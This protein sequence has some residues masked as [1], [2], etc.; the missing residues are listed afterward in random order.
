[1]ICEKESFQK[2][3]DGI[4]KLIH[5]NGKKKGRHKHRLYKC[6]LCGNFHIT[7][8]TKNLRTPKDKYP[9]KME[10]QGSSKIKNV[11]AMKPL[12][13]GKKKEDQ[14][15]TTG[16]MMTKEQADALKRIINSQNL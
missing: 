10:R 7:T 14:K 3:E 15:L 2:Y 12:I 8:I 4:D 6:D 16:K 5:L 11:P 9:M 1:M 13:Q